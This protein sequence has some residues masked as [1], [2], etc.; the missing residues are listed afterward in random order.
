[1][2]GLAVKNLSKGF[3]SLAVL[4]NIELE[5]AE[6]EFLILVGP[7]G[8]GKSTLLSLIAGLERPDA[9]EIHIAG[10]RSEHL[11]PQERDIAMVFQSYALYPNMTVAQN[12]GFGLEMRK[13]PRPER[14]AMVARVAEMLQLTPL[15]SRRP[16]QLSGGQRQRVAMGRALARQPKVFLFDEPLS[17]L[18][19]KLRVEMRAEIKLLH[20]RLKTT[21]VYVTHDQVEA[22]TL[23]HKIAVMKDGEIQQFGTPDEIYQ[24]P[25]NLFVAGF[26]GAPAINILRARIVVEEGVPLLRLAQE[27]SRLRLPLA[28]ARLAAWAGREVLLGLRPEHIVNARGEAVPE[29]GLRFRAPVELVEPTGADTYVVASLDGQR[30]TCRVQPSCPAVVGEPMWLDVLPHEPSLFDPST[31]LRLG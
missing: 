16:G 6:G 11:S 28:N 30:L 8:C 27:G 15:L 1:M 20:Q 21:A 19:A 31:G 7:S 3:G 14:E 18:D 25:A 4:K 26:M 5:I 2:T 12:L 9:G 17:N 29:G 23:G 24:R 13:V 22:M 10:K